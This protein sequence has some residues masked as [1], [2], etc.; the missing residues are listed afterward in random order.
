MKG[1]ASPRTATKLDEIQPGCRSIY[2]A[3]HITLVQLLEWLAEK[4]RSAFVKWIEHGLAAC[5]A[6]AIILRHPDVF[7]SE[8]LGKMCRKRLKR[9]APDYQV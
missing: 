1:L 2:N 4:K 3:E 8:A 5:T 9:E 6:E 7:K